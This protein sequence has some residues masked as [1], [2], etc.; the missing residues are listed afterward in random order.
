MPMGRPAAVVVLAAGEGT[1]M[2]SRLPKVLHSIGGRSL[3]GHAV[4]AG[5]SLDP[6][7]LA[8]VVGSGRDLVIDH[9]SRID[10]QAR[11]VVQEDREVAGRYGTGYATR[12]ALEALPPLEG[13]VVVTTGDTPLL[14]AQTLRALVEAHESTGHAAT[15]LTAVVPDPEGYGRIL[16]GPDGAV[17]A[18]VEHKDATPE[19]REVAEINSGIFV[20]DAPALGD[21]LTR[22]K[23]DNSQGEEY[24]TDVLGILVEDGRSVG[25]VPAEDWTEIL[26]VNNRVQL[27]ELGRLLNDRTLRAWMLAGVTV[28]DPATTWVDDTV[29][30][31][32]DVTL[33]PHTQLRG[34]TVVESGAEIG[35]ETTLTD[36]RIGAEATVVRTHGEG[37]HVGDGA[38]VGPFAY[39][40][41]GTRLGTKGKIGTF[42][43][44]KN[45]EIGAGSKVPHLSYVGDATLGEHCNIGAGTIFANYDGVDKHHTDIGDAVFVGSDSVLVA[46]R[47]IADGAYVAAGSTV[48]KD[49]GPGELGVARGTQ[50]NVAGWVERKRPG[51]RT[52]Q[53]AKRALD[54]SGETGVDDA[55]ASEGT[56]R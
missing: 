29:T 4:R 28:V 6:E 39:L 19:Q 20:F 22:V 9:L 5:R 52:A 46:P 56:I 37:A 36:C 17:T 42:V 1:R 27:A 24:L 31:A 44:T 50:R 38:S 16:R 41:P 43:E 3:V 35:P 25:A 7:H 23:T 26:G 54:G 53:A 33:R 18:I 13:S 32:P 12:L 49:I 48:V 21:A 8:V 14:T 55:D 40:R 15:V 10:P 30:L 45:A 2:R 51:T 47:T 11:P 34:E